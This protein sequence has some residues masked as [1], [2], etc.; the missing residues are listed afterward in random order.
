M[1]ADTSCAT[2]T[3]LSSSIEEKDKGREP[4]RALLSA[5]LKRMSIG[6]MDITTG[7]TEARN[8]SD[9]TRCI[10]HRNGH[11]Y[12]WNVDVHWC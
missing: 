11:G 8:V 12:Q 7:Y 3:S 5:K 2:H 9:S 4:E 10:N 1:P 6:R